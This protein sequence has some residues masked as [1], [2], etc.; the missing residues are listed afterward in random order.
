MRS[1][2]R[3]GIRVFVPV[4]ALV[5][6]LLAAASAPPP[7]SIDAANEGD[8]IT[9]TASADME[10]DARTVWAVITDYDHLADFIPDMNSSRVLTHDGHHLL[11]AQTGEFRF[12]VFRQPVQVQLD[13]VEMPTRRLVAYA[14][15][16][17][18]K[19][20]EGRYAIASLPSGVVRLT[21]SGRLI[22]DFP[23]PP[24]IGGMLLR[25]ELSKQFTALVHEIVRRDGLTRRARSRP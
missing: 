14:V 23:V 10:V 2:W 22:P 25:R 19:E 6:G 24:L 4:L 13:V 11:V 15:G 9:V 16:G 21:Y 18:L 8:L 7:I 20:M 5:S 17:N 3:L 1:T 12:L